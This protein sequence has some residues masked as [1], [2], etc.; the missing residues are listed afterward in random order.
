MRKFLECQQDS[1]TNDQE[2]PLDSGD[3]DEVFISRYWKSRNLNTLK[4]STFVMTGL[5]YSSD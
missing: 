1:E 2:E 4:F 3:T 5:L